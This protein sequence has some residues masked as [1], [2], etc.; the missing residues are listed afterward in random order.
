VSKQHA[1]CENVILAAVSGFEDE[2]HRQASIDAGFD[3]RFVKPL[4]AGELQDFLQEI[5]DHSN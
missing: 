5:A 3:Y 4:R 1:G 2:A